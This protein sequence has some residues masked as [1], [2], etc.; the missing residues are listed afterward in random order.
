M[1]TTSLY[2]YGLLI[3]P[4]LF[5]A[6]ILLNDALKMYQNNTLKVHPEALDLLETEAKHGSIDAAFLLA[7]AYR[8]GKAGV[9][10]Y[11][12]AY[13]WYKIAAEQGDADAMLMLG[14]IH[15]KQIKNA[16]SNLEAARYWFKKAAAKGVDEAI[17]MLELLER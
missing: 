4:V 16:K 7:T 15:Y 6:Q 17:E 11:T 1:K 3:A 12:K 9:V 5:A 8:N 2:R 14:W 10:D 13:Q